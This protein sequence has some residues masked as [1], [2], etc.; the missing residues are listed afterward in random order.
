MS[1]LVSI[2]MPVFNAAFFLPATLQSVSNQKYS[3]WEL[4]IVDDGSTDGSQSICAHFKEG[5][6]QNCMILQSNRNQSGAGTCRNIGLQHCK[7]DYIIF[8]DSD[9]LL[10]RFCLEQRI[11]TIGK[12]DLAIF[13]QYTFT[14]EINS[15]LPIFNGPVSNRAD[16]IAAFTRMEAPWQTMAGIWKKETLQKLKGFDESLVFMEDPDLHLRALLDKDLEIIFCYNLPADNYYRINNMQG[17]KAYSFYK[18]S[19]ISRMI[20]LD[21][22]IVL[23]KHLPPLEKRENAKHIRKGY[24][25][26]LR[27]F[28]IARFNDFKDDILKLNHRLIDAG[29]LSMSDK[30]KLNFLFSIYISSSPIV[31]QMRLKGLAYR[32]IK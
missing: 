13:K 2:I 25:S 15:N 7:G 29:I 17:E 14:N 18:N 8:L 1:G 32:L 19:I 9:D 11:N 27:D 5:Q 23:T 24:L 10:E 28:V 4:V 12:N 3:N 22:L 26:F 16:A 20:F 6:E 21:K 31:K 30:L